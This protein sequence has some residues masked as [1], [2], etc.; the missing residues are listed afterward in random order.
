MVV[1]RELLLERP[2]PHS[3]EAERAIL[4]AI[5]LDNN[6]MNQA[7]TLLMPDHFYV[8]AHQFVYRAMLSLS[9]HGSEIN[10]ILLGEELRRE[11]VLEQTGGVA[12]ISELTYG[13]PHFTNI[14]A[15][16]KVV[17]GK[18]LRRQLIRVAN[19]MI[20]E[21]LAEEETEEELL[22]HAGAYLFSLYDERVTR[23][24][25]PV[26]KLVEEGVPEILARRESGNPVTGLRTGLRELDALTLGLQPS[27]LIIVAARPGM[28][29]T[30]LGLTIAQN[31]AFQSG[32]VVAVFSLEMSKE[33][34]RERFI[35]Q[36]ARIDSMKLRSGY[37]N[38][39][40]LARIAG[41]VEDFKKARIFIDDTPA[42][43]PM[44]ARARARQLA[45][46]NGGKLD[47]IVA[48][49]LQLFRPSEKKGSREQ[50]VSS[51]SQ[52]WKA[53][54]KELKVPVILNSQLNR[55]PE[56]RQDRRPQLSDLRESGAI[57]QDADIVAFIYREEMYKR[58]DE[59]A[60]LAEVILAK[61]RNG[62]ADTKRVTFIK[63]FTRFEDLFQER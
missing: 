54:A 45:M 23:A 3:A 12:F 27:N 55:A 10:P 58:T 53:I 5:L 61:N 22:D 29:K 13:L 62:S 1:N 38:R 44:Y 48:D 41:A 2:L 17:R 57:E 56:G 47:L 8:H 20:Q 60:G 16:A 19:K 18:A 25:V 11:E 42:I 33:E 40:E 52:E 46:E 9:A 50:E 43:T 7:I 32:A 36:Y 30:A 34:L 39:D 37:L 15:Y 31:A 26:G 63:E 4:G 24:F 49:Y 59:N 35:A 6:L 14:G 28:G 21:S 51:V